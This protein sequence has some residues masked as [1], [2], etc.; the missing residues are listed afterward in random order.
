MNLRL[1]FASLLIATLGTPTFAAEATS[2]VPKPR[3]F[4]YVL[5]PV[6]RLHDDNAW[7]DADNATI[8]RHFNHLK[9]ATERGQIVLAGRTLEPGDKTFGL[10]IFEAADEPAARAFMLSDP[11]VVEKI[12]MAELHPYAIAL[13]RQ[14]K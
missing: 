14:K 5:K 10:V 13:Q 1:L 7:T 4:V 8:G 9:A 12:M 11:A 6:T 3:T 2:P